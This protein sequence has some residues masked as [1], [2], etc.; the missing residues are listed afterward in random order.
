MTALLL[1]IDGKVTGVC[2]EINKYTRL[3]R[4]SVK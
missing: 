1:A 4:P 3:L 2:D